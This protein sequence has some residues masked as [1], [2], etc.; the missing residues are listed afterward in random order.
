MSQIDDL[1]SAVADEISD[2]QAILTKLQTNPV[3]QDNPDIAVAIQQLQDSHKAT[4]AILNAPTPA[5]V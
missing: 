1:K 2:V 4:Q 5:T 3:V